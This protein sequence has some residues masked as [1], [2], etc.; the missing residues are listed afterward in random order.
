MNSAAAVHHLQKLIA[1]Y[2]D[3]MISMQRELVRR[4]AVGPDN[5]GPDEA[6]KADFS[7]P[8]FENWASR[9]TDYPAPDDRVAGGRRPTWWPCCRAAGR[10]KSG[11]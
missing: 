3:D 9:V 1:G 5:H 4:V 7:W 2:P 10:K 6:E 11:S 8:N